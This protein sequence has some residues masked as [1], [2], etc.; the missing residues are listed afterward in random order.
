MT[1]PAVVAVERGETVMVTNSGSF[2]V[3]LAGWT[4]TDE[5]AKHSYTFAGNHG[6]RPPAR[7][8]EEG[9]IMNMTVDR[10]KR[11]RVGAGRPER[12]EQ[13]GPAGCTVFP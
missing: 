7:Q 1:G 12:R 8:S 4:S 9:M 10:L 3:N 5:G 13:A 11:D 2:P 6:A